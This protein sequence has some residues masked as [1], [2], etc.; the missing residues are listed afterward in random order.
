MNTCQSMSTKT[1]AYTIIHMQLYVN[2]KNQFQSYKEIF[3]SLL[4]KKVPK[5]P[6]HLNLKHEVESLLNL[7]FGSIFYQK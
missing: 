6:V 1:A 7:T 5:T 3:S 2:I 4:I